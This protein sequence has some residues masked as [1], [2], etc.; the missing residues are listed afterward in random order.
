MFFWP[1]IAITIAVFLKKT[2]AIETTDIRLHDGDLEHCLV[3]E[4]K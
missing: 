3:K 1:C 2:A 4:K